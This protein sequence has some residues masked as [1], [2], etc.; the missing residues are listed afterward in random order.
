MSKKNKNRHKPWASAGGVPTSPH[1]SGV[2]RPILPSMVGPTSGSSLSTP[3]EPAASVNSAAAAL[4]EDGLSE[5]PVD[6]LVLAANELV[7]AHPL[8]ARGVGN[9]AAVVPDNHQAFPANGER[10]SEPDAGTAAQEATSNTPAAGDRDQLI[11]AIRATRQLLLALR[12]AE[13]AC[14]KATAKAERAHEDAVNAKRA[15]DERESA[16]KQREEDLA[17]R[18]AEVESRHLGLFALE[19]SAREG[20]PD[21]LREAR[22]VLRREFADKATELEGRAAAVDVQ[23]QNLRRDR[24]ELQKEQVS[25]AWARAELELRVE[26]QSERDRLA[27]EQA[28]KRVQSQV[29]ALRAQVERAEGR[30][31]ELGQQAEARKARVS[32][33]ESVLNAAGGR[34]IGDLVAERDALRKRVSD[35][36]LELMRRPGQDTVE[37]Y[38]A[39]AAR[40]ELVDGENQQLRGERA[41]IRAELQQLRIAADA[42]GSQEDQR[43]SL[44]ATNRRYKEMNATLRSELDAQLTQVAGQN[45]FRELDRMDR[46]AALQAGPN[47]LTNLVELKRLVGELRHRMALQNPALFYSERTVRCF[48]GGLAM[49]RLQLLQGI[50]GTGKTSLP[51]AVADALGGRADITAV[52]AGW[53]DRQD[54]LG[55]YNE[56]DKKYHETEFIKALYRAQCPEWKDRVCIVVLDEMNLS[57]VEQFGADLLS[58]L[59]CPRGGGARLP[60]LHFKHSHAPT[61]LVDGMEIRL[62]PNVWF[63]GTANHDETT[64]DF[65]DKTYDRA[66]AMELP[67]NPDRFTA[68]RE[69][70]PPPA[71]C[72][73]L[74][75]LFDKARKEQRVASEQARK[76]IGSLEGAL[77]EKLGVGWGNRLERQ[78]GDFVPVVVA[79]GGTV[80]EAV[81]HLVSSKLLRKLKNRHDVRSSALQELRRTLESS[82]RQLDS[83]QPFQCQE[84]LDELSRSRSFEDGE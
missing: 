67:R 40:L 64:K 31:K 28:A 27:E 48:L 37:Q 73:S 57:Y 82:W 35:L 29:D 71:S 80:G 19:A 10:E 72:A 34:S 56:F 23:E 59:E 55:Y 3:T 83:A 16:L 79:A 17:A 4:V 18:C 7:E 52:Q 51:R 26:L 78:I 6:A 33:L 81:D 54:L 49:S 38:K 45:P 62:P 5:A 74:L 13:A 21:K 60:L 53:R 77:K 8:D 2:S 69:S 25:V 22:E 75:A 9:G 41:A 46:D 61:L 44:E 20:F 14:K 42:V 68:T 65:A 11:D 76:F 84:L 43:K 58:E 39:A 32:E 30:A 1:S 63:V 12:T 50:S 24:L 47:G 70:V 66:H 36:G 15:C